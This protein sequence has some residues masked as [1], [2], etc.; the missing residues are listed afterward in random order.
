MTK[1]ILAKQKCSECLCTPKRIVSKERAAQII[2]DCLDTQNHFV[3]HKSSDG[4]IVHCR[5]VHDLHASQAYQM[6]IRL[7]IEVEEREMDT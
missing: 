7:G 6:A 3:C 1:L 4:E 2:S 5:G